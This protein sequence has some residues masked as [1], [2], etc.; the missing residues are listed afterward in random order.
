MNSYI[1][2]SLVAGEVEVIVDNQKSFLKEGELLAQEPSKISMK[3]LKA[4]RLAGI[5]INRL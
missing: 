2:F 5:Q 1:V 3:T 4:S